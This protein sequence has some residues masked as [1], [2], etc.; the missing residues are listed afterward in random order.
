MDTTPLIG[1]ISA[2]LAVFVLITGR[3]GNYSNSDRNSIDKDVD[4]L[5]QTTI[6][7]TLVPAVLDV[8]EHE[9]LA[10]GEQESELLDKLEPALQPGLRKIARVYKCQHVAKQFGRLVSRVSGGGIVVE[11]IFISLVACLG[12]N[13]SILAASLGTSFLLLWLCLS[14]MF[15]RAINIQEVEDIK[16]KALNV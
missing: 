11:L 13:I 4:F 5:S 12:A 14:F 6:S 16:E 15:I 10:Y 9:P 2:F 1:T 8:F 7:N 3:S